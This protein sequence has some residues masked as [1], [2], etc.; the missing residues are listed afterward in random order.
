MA[1]NARGVHVSP[2]VYSREV[3]LQYAV[4]SLGITTL[5]LAGETQRGPAFQPMHIENWRQ[6]AETFG[7]T[8]T[9]KFKGSQYPKYELPYI[10]KSYLT[11]SKQLE[12]VRV[13]GLSGY[14][15][16]PAWVVTAKRNGKDDMVVA[17]LRSRGHYEKYHKF[18]VTTD[19]CDCPSSSYDKLIYEVG[20][21]KRSG[22][23]CPVVGYNDIVKLKPYNPLYA[24]GNDC[25]GYKIEGLTDG[26]DV[27]STNYGRFTVYGLKGYQAYKEWKAEDISEGNANYFEYPV[28]LNPYDKDF[29]LKVLGTD[30]QDGEAPV[31][32]ESLYDVAL[33]QGIKDGV[34][35]PTHITQINQDL[36][37]YNV[38]DPSDYCG[39]EPIAGMLRLQES[40]LQRKNIGQRYVADCSTAASE[41]TENDPNI[42]AHPYDY[43][44]GIPLTISEIFGFNSEVKDEEWINDDPNSGFSA[45]TVS[46]SGEPKTE[47]IDEI[48]SGNNSISQDDIYAFCE[49]SKAQEKVSSVCFKTPKSKR[50][51]G[52]DYSLSSSTV[53]ALEKEIAG[54]DGLISVMITDKLIGQIFTVTRYVDSEGKAHYLYRFYPVNN[55]KKWR[56]KPVQTG[57]GETEQP[58]KNADIVPIIDKLQDGVG[59]LSGRTKTY[60]DTGENSGSTRLVIV[61]NLADGL[62][63]RLVDTCKDTRTDCKS[64]DVT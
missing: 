31:Y 6:F 1:D 55:V 3:D 42:F 15:A 62:Y 16:G 21:I 27:S 45:Y 17:V 12:V 10:A 39:L 9:E 26:F 35:E 19:S 64:K 18:D 13:L 60:T 54:P 33:A 11:E 30:P 23:T 36:E 25:V 53:E 32:V 50:V 5:G 8:S 28:S 61:K 37:F 44:K 20:E 49:T 34:N 2:G 63:Y 51:L 48:F 22:D 41:E 43:E 57:D 52:R 4:K 59:D 58:N 29:I 24:V 56:D 47:K 46:V 38:Y 40:A 14:K 7:G